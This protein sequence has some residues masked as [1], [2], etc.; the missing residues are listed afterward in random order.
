[1]LNSDTK[2]LNLKDLYTI[3]ATTYNYQN[4]KKQFQESNSKT[5]HRTIRPPDHNKEIAKKNSKNGAIT[6]FNTLPNNLK[7]LTTSGKNI[8]R[9]LTQHVIKKYY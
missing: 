9:T 6:F 7:V 5:R 1:M 3:K 8:K 4:L 2:L